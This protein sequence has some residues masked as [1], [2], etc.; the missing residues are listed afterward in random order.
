MVEITQ[1]DGESAD[2]MSIPWIEAH[3]L[4]GSE[5]LMK[6]TRNNRRDFLKAAAVGVSALTF[7]QL[8]GRAGSVAAP[9]IV[10]I[11]TDDQGYA[12]IGCYGA[13][14]FDTPN[15]D[16]MAEEGV[17]FT[18][19]YVSQAVCSASRASLLTGCYNGRVGIQGALMPRSNIGLHPDEETIASMLKKR[20]YATGI[21][22]KWHLGHHREFLP[23]Q[24][25]FDEYFGLPY[26]NDMW[27]YHYDGTP[28]EGA[29]G[30]YPPLPLLEGNEK[31][32]EVT[33]LAD[34]AR[35][36]TRYTER[37]V[38]FIKKHKHTPFFL[39]LPHSMPHTP[40]GV[41][42]TYHGKSR[43]GLYGDV[44]MEIDWSVGMVL[45][46][47]D[48]C[49][50]D[51]KTLVI[52]ASDNG[53]WLSFGTH[54]GSAVPL[55]EGK[56]TMWEGGARVPCIMR[57]P[58]RIPAGSTCNNIAATID[59]LPTI[60]AVTAAALPQKRIDG[61]NILPLIEG[62][63]DVDPRKSYYF[64][65]GEQL[66][67]VRQGRWKL[68]LPHAYD[69]IAGGTVGEHG[70]PGHYHKAQTGLALYDLATD[71]GE[72][73]DVIQ[74]H[75]DVVSELELLAEVARAD[76]GDSLTDRIGGGIRQPGRHIV[77][78][79]RQHHLG[80]G[81]SITL[82]TLFSPKYAA[83][84]NDAL[85]DGYS[86]SIDFNDG[87]W[88]GYEGVGLDAMIDL[89][90]AQSVKRIQCGFLQDQPSWI[91]TPAAIQIAVSSDGDEY[92]ILKDER[93]PQITSSAVSRIVHYPAE[94]TDPGDVRWIRVR[95]ENIGTCPDW[96]P[97][98]G[99]K[100]W[101]FVDEIIIE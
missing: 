99:M 34:Q 95:A 8:L 62:E 16:R 21:F 55:R 30:R 32:E 26:S 97:G 23:L 76:L 71:P 17:R 47:I 5:G 46:T 78:K 22:G 80:V 49:G 61:V 52:F 96:H 93:S 37:A 90:S 58:G 83:S 86:G 64:F 41:S 2:A 77:P 65:Y 13:K 92:A 91:F 68:H 59:I 11:F 33:T 10:I 15:L 89:G 28:D 70:N 19:F 63:P 48:T 3:G 25:G 31:V 74:A 14:N 51:E 53:P 40:L 94:R 81:K 24:H 57:W 38:A 60:A 29:K 66:H 42:E 6:R 73:I 43:Q 18:N 1:Y 69:S 35:L 9:N 56:G 45:K 75:P 85:I 7:P 87:A 101:L 82:K 20:G 50:L 36:T 4:C 39:Y 67:A 100:A 54:A 88:Q 44:M 27:P 12:D 98:A 79:I 72:T 84:G